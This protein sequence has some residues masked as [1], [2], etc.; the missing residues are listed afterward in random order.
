M[1]STQQHQTVEVPRMPCS[2]RAGRPRKYHT[3]EERKAARAESQSRYIKQKQDADPELFKESMR[4]RKMRD[5]DKFRSLRDL[6]EEADKVGGT[7]AEEADVVEARAYVERI[8]TMRR[9][10]AKRYY[11]SHPDYRARH[12]AKMAEYCRNKQ[13]ETQKKITE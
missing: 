8:R 4:A 5:A 7:R 10:A 2:N 13:K 6:V 12:Y 3:E 11:H 1:A 9:E